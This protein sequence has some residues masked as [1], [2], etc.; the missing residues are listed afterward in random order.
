MEAEKIFTQ[1]KQRENWKTRCLIF[2]CSTRFVRLYYR[3]IFKVVERM[4]KV[5]MYDFCSAA[6]L[7]CCCVHIP[8]RNI[9]NILNTSKLRECNRFARILWQAQLQRCLSHACIAIIAIRS[10]V[11]ST[12]KC[13]WQ[14]S[15]VAIVTLMPTRFVIESGFYFAR[16][17][18]N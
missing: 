8:L 4:L 6:Y 16:R 1:L 12:K 11:V 17:S 2:L 15:S 3:A 7:L 13:R 10:V 5:L 9:P 18:V 14:P